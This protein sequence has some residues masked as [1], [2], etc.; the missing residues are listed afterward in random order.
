MDAF[1]LYHQPGFFRYRKM[2]YIA[3]PSV[4]ISLGIN[5]QN[6]RNIGNQCFHNKTLAKGL[7]YKLKTG[8]PSDETI[9]SNQKN[10][11]N[12]CLAR[13]YNGV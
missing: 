2:I 10:G 8:K 1:V 7:K 12:R 5:V 4:W 13:L 11:V 3:P 6:L 9:L